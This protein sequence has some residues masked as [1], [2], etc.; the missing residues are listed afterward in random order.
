VD[1]SASGVCLEM[2]AEVKVGA[3]L[4]IRP[5]GAPERMG[6]V[7]VV[8][9][10]RHRKGKGHILGCEFLETPSLVTLLLFG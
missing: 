7:A 9:Q 8:V 10:H 4:K 6:W 1:R 2:E 3:I 5:T